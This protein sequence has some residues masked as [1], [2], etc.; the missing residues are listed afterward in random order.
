M[1]EDRLEFNIDA[2]YELRSAP[3]VVADLERRGSKILEAC[4]GEEAG[5]FMY[6]EQGARDPQG[7][8]QVTV[9]AGSEEA[10]I[11]NGENNTLVRNFGRASG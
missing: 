2:F 7:R 4:G 1:A 11:D 9:V 6:S 8:H 5:Y 10:R 3:G